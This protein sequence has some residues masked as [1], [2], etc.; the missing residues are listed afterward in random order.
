MKTLM[1]FWLY[2]GSVFGNLN[3]IL[4][5]LWKFDQ[6]AYVTPNLHSFLGTFAHIYSNW[7][8][9][10]VVL[11]LNCDCNGIYPWN[12]IVFIYLLLGYCLLECQHK[13]FPWWLD[14][15]WENAKL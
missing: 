1:V 13:N 15:V 8:P 5:G 2:I 10:F 11:S 12:L 6:Y 9:T 14:N 3:E 7:D 4:I